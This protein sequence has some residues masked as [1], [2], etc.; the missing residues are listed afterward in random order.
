VHR[1]L[2]H[3]PAVPLDVLTGILP[4]ADVGV[5]LLPRIAA[6]SPD[7]VAQLAASADPVLRMLVATRRD[8]P[9]DIVEKLAQDPDTKVV[10][11]V[12]AHP[13]LGEQRLLDMAAH[14]ELA[15]HPDATAAT[16][17]CCLDVPAAR[18]IAARHPALPPATITE[19]LDDPDESVRRASAANPA[20]P[21][22]AAR[23]LL[24]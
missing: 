8:L 20:L 24:P 7:E 6:A 21:R 5:T 1:R 16:L 23:A 10:R 17:L 9:S 14:R 3:N 15:A 2:A 11:A 13:G 19:L 18:P 12:A 4:T 22:H